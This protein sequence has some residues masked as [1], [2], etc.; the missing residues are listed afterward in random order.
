METKR[1]L[2]LNALVIEEEYLIAADIE[3]T[4]KAAGAA[5]VDIFRNLTDLYEKQVD[6]SGFQVAIVEAKLGDPKV[7][8]FS[9]A[10]HENG[11]AVVMTSADSTLRSL[12]TGSVS[13]EKPF[14]SAA[15]LSACQAARQKGPPPEASD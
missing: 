14:D 7:V 12:F 15:L 4:L 1:M 2:G 10:L 8:A 6:P 9:S 3:Q 5:K 13:L 11:V